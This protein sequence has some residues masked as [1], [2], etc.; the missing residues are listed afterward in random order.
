MSHERAPQ[1]RRTIRRI[2]VLLALVF[3]GLTAA[4]G[5]VVGRRWP[6]ESLEALL[7]GNTRQDPPGW[8]YVADTEQPRY[9]MMRV[10][11]R[12]EVLVFGGFVNARIEATAR[13]DA[14]HLPT[15]Q[16]RSRKPMP[17][18]FTHANAVL[19]GDTVWF[20]G[21]FEGNHPGPATARVWKY[22]PATDTWNAGPP[23]PA[24]R[25]GGALVAR[26][27]TLHYVGGWLPDRTTDSPDHWQLHP[28]D[29]VWRARAPL[30]IPRGH[31]SATVVANMIYAIGGVTGHDPVPIDLAVVHRYDPAT[32]RWE[33]RRDAPKALS[34]MEPSTM[35]FGRGTLLVG[36]RSRPTGEENL[37]DVYFFDAVQDQWRHVGL[38]PV[39]MLGGFADLWRD[40][41]VVGLGAPRYSWPETRESWIRAIYNSW[42][43]ST[44]MPVPLGEVA[45]GVV[46]DAMLVVGEGNGATLRFDLARGAWHILDGAERP[47]IGNHHAAEVANGRWFLLGGFGYASE[48]VVQIFDPGTARWTLGPPMPF[49]AG[50]SASAL[51]GS[52]IF[53]GGGIV[54]D[55][56]TGAAA[57]LDVR[58]LEWRSVAPMPRP[59]NH[60]ASGTDGQRWYVF[61]GRGPGSGNRNEVANGF[62]DV[63]I[64]DPVANAWRVSDGTPG[65]PAPMPQGRGGTGKAAYINGEFWVVGGET[66]S[67]AGANE[68]GAYARVDIYNPLTNTWRLGPAL[69]TARHGIFPVVHDGRVLVAGGGVQAGASTSAVLELLWADQ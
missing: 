5:F 31:L 64:Y 39:R 57:A 21:G 68:R 19:L 16:W 51:I 12:D 62:A 27:D 22:A 41:L 14:L 1:S 59:R 8:R 25:G 20:A 67:G 17:V 23:L 32:D 46:D 58:S 24:P 15:G 6:I 7:R 42:W 54:G 65:A 36:G 69:P 63:Q 47:A 40:S 13:V 45:A 56:T 26:G 50:S 35:L 2:G 61:G 60:A 34:H 44:P 53:V 33:P 38:T 55:T 4:S 28:G 30:P 18:A 66:L 11:Y 29:S 9:E 37:R 49:A 43:S 3:G 52:E 10:R 48:G